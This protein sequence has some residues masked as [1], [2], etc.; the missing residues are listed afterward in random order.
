[1]PSPGTFDAHYLRATFDVITTGISE[2]GRWQVA[3]GSR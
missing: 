3:V 1:M 2:G